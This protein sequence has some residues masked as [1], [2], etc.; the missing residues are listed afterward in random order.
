MRNL[1][2]GLNSLIECAKGKIYHKIANR[3][4]DTQKNAKAY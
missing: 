3:L 4:N 1:Q 2:V